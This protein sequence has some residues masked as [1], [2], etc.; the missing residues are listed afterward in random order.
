[1]SAVEREKATVH[2]LYLPGIPIPCLQVVDGLI[3]G[4]FPA[5]HWAVPKQ[6]PHCFASPVSGINKTLGKAQP[7]TDPISL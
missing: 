2:K 1:M 5:W 4:W 3:Q 6:E 7:I